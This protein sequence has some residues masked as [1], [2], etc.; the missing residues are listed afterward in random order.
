[1]LWHKGF[2]SNFQGSKELMSCI[3]D[4][5]GDSSD[6]SLVSYLGGLWVIGG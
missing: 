6:K 3:I 1:M 5:G 2:C 4:K